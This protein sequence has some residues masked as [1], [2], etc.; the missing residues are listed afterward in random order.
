MVSLRLGHGAALTVHRT[1]IHSRAA[2]SLPAVRWA[3][4]IPHQFRRIRMISL[5]GGLMSPP[6]SGAQRLFYL[7]A[8]RTPQSFTLSP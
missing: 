4:A 6:Y 1:V 7:C 5:C 8:E 2:A 3:V